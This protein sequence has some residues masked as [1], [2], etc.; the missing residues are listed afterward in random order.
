MI[1]ELTGPFLR[2]LRVAFEGH[3][4]IVVWESLRPIG[5]DDMDSSIQARRVARSGVPVGRTFQVNDVALGDQTE[6]RIAAAGDAG[7]NFVVTWKSETSNGTDTD[8]TSIQAR[9]FGFLLR[10]GFE[11]GDLRFWSSVTSRADEQP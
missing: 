5:P 7:G 11:T 1:D 4:F 2:P 8:G 3:D 6:P 10:D 9:R